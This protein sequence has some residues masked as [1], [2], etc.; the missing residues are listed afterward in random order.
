MTGYRGGRGVGGEVLCKRRQL[1]LL[2]EGERR[3]G[4]DTED[5]HLFRCPFMKIGERER[6]PSPPAS[7]P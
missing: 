4:L 3:R 1:V 6:G 7:P 5:E 2:S